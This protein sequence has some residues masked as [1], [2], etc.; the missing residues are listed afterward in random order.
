MSGRERQIHMISLIC[1]SKKI[2]Q[3]INKNHVHRYREQIGGCQK[4]GVG[5]MG[6]G[7]QKVRKKKTGKCCR[8]LLNVSSATLSLNT[9]YNKW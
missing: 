5:E 3:T 4:L 7:G 9:F 8:Y 2:P 1:V 6:E